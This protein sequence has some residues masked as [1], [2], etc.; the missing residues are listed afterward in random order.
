MEYGRKYNFAGGPAC[1]PLAVLK[2]AQESLLNYNGTGISIMEMSHRSKE[3]THIWNSARASFRKLL[4]IPESYQV[5]FILDDASIQFE[6]VPMNFLAGRSRANY[7]VTGYWSHVACEEAQPFCQPHSVWKA[8]SQFT[9]KIETT[10]WDIDPTGAYLHYCSNETGNGTTLYDFP[11]SSLPEGMP[12][13][14]DMSSEFCARQIDVSKYGVIYAGVQKNCGPSGVTVVIAR[15]DLLKK[16]H[17]LKVTPPVI[18]YA[19]INDVPE[20]MFN[21]PATWSC[22]VTGLYV[23]YMNKVGLKHFE[24]LAIRR[25]KLVYDVIDSSAGYYVN[26]VDPKCRSRT[27]VVFH[28]KGGETLTKKFLEGADKAGLIQLAGFAPVGGIRAS[29]YNAM[30]MEGAEA[31]IAFM[32][33]FRDENKV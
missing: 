24:D 26:K 27:N 33:K 9:E 29:L 1:L 8:G 32:K 15:K 3:F 5:F 28:L 23:D 31:L 4:S 6:A 19:L 21:T 11:Y 30:P 20:Q 16:E 18:N 14:C 10:G 13:M 17:V 7:L 25:S 2:Q 12:L 22:Y